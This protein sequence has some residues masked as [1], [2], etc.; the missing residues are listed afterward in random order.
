MFFAV[1]YVD[2]D[3]FTKPLKLGS[4]GSDVSLLQQILKNKGYFTYPEIT[5][6]YGSYTLSAVASFQE[7]Q[8]LEVV[9]SVGPLTRTLLNVEITQSSSTAASSSAATTPPISIIPPLGGGFFV[10]G[11]GYTPGFGGGSGAAA[12]TP[13]VPPAPS[14]TSLPSISGTVGQGF[15]LTATTGSWNGSPTA[16][17]YQ[18]NADGVAISGATAST[19]LLT[20][21]ELG[22]AITVT[23]TATNSTGSTAAT[24]AATSAVAAAPSNTVAP[25]I[26]GSAGQGFTLTA[27]T[28]SWDG[29]PTGYTYQW[30]ADGIAISGATASTYLLTSAELG[31]VITVAVTATNAIGSNSASSVATSAVVGGAIALL[32]GET[33][34]FAADFTYA[35]A[36][37]RV[38]TKAPAVT[39]YAVDDILVHPGTSPKLV[40]GPAGTYVWSP[41]NMF[42]NSDSPAT[43]TVTTAATTTYTVTVTGTGSLTLSGGG[44]GTVSAG[45]PLTFTATTTSVTFTL[46]GSLTRIQLNRGPVATDYLATTNAARYGNAFTYSTTTHSLLG[47]LV[48]NNATGL[49]LWDRDLTNAVWVKTNVTAAKDQTGIEGSVNGASSLT[50]TSNAGTVLQSITS[51]SSVRYFSP[52]VKRITGSGTIEVTLDNGSTWTNITSNLSTTDWYRVTTYETLANPTVGFRLGTSGDSIA[53]DMA[54]LENTVWT[55]PI[56]TFGLSVT[57]ARDDTFASTTPASAFTFYYDY[58]PVVATST[59]K[60]R[61]ALEGAVGTLDL[62]RIRQTSAGLLS[63]FANDNNVTQASFTFAAGDV[64]NT[65]TQFTTRIAANNFAASRDGGEF[66]TDTAGTVPD[67]V[68]FRLGTEAGGGNS[69]TPIIVRRIVFTDRSVSDTDLPTW[70][71]NTPN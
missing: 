69:S 27:N 39:E 64:D 25:S 68:L 29:T 2:A 21:A 44:A 6:Y 23:V 47:L 37:K 43:Q 30:S 62:T 66:G 5:G 11:N 36:S 41:H 18:W 70:R 42:L 12:S 34:G 19:Y 55:S 10:P 50:A 7:A 54:G 53:V 40:V 15:T 17:A 45:S 13:S 4:H 52:F 35:T 31:K 57:R 32:L 33:T 67:V 71:Y 60:T 38:A 61:I 48:E 3:V 14:N 65:R 51:V 28:G 26:S 9:G 49:A 1:T 56:P 59:S 22:K 46:S 20:S 24:S 8:G 16:Y 58:I 63:M